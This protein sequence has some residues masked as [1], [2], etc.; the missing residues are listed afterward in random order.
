MKKNKIFFGIIVIL[1]IIFAIL[2][3]VPNK[4]EETIKIGAILPLSGEIANWVLL[5]KEVLN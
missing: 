4:T 3:I 5:L 2:L 1:I